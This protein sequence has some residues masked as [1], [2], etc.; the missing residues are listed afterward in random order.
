MDEIKDIKNRDFKKEAELRIPLMVS[1]EGEGKEALNYSFSRF[2][3]DPREIL[4]HVEKL[5]ND[6]LVTTAIVTPEKGEALRSRLSESIRK[7]GKQ[8]STEEFVFESYEIAT[9]LHELDP[10]N[11]PTS[12]AAIKMAEELLS[13]A[14]VALRDERLLNHAEIDAKQALK[15]AMGSQYAFYAEEDNLLT[16]STQIINDRLMEM[17]IDRDDPEDN[18]KTIAMLEALKQSIAQQAIEEYKSKYGH[19]PIYVEAEK[20]ENNIQTYLSYQYYGAY[21]EYERQMLTN[22]RVMNGDSMAVQF[23]FQKYAT[24]IVEKSIRADIVHNSVVNNYTFSNEVLEKLEKV[25]LQQY[26]GHKT[27]GVEQEQ[28]YESLHNLVAAISTYRHGIGNFKKSAEVIEAVF[29]D[30]YIKQYYPGKSRETILG[31]A[32]GAISDIS[33]MESVRKRNALRTEAEMRD[34]MHRYNN[35]TKGDVYTN[36]V[37]KQI[38]GMTK[39]DLYGEKG[40]RRGLDSAMFGLRACLASSLHSKTSVQTGE[41]M[42][43]ECVK[44]YIEETKKEAQEFM[45]MATGQQS[46]LLGPFGISAMLALLAIYKDLKAQAANRQVAKIE[47]EAFKTSN[48]VSELKTENELKAAKFFMPFK[49]SAENYSE[50]KFN[51]REFKTIKGSIFSVF[52]KD[53]S[54]FYGIAS[55]SSPTGNIDA[56]NEYKA[57]LHKE[58]FESIFVKSGLIHRTTEEEMSVSEETIQDLARLRKEESE[59]VAKMQKI[60]TFIT[61]NSLEHANVVISDLENAKRE[62]ESI[63]KDLTSIKVR[64]RDIQ[65]AQERGFKYIHPTGE[66]N[67]TIKSLSVQT[68]RAIEDGLP[69]VEN[70][71]GGKGIVTSLEI[72]EQITYGNAEVQ[73]TILREQEKVLRRAILEEIAHKERKEAESIQN[74]QGL[75]SKILSQQT[76]TPLGSAAPK[77]M[78]Q[79]KINTLV[80]AYMET[81]KLAQDFIASQRAKEGI[82]G[83]LGTL[84]YDGIEPTHL[85]SDIS[86]EEIKTILSFTSREN[87]EDPMQID[88]SYAGDKVTLSGFS[89]QALSTEKEMNEKINKEMGYKWTR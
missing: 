41:S 48:M 58:L 49:N 29:D 81:E 23:Y 83:P 79:R 59:L 14:D 64:I 80:G 24:D 34:L 42:A 68:L 40:R 17:E 86:D 78:A 63:E 85:F 54:T 15:E 89:Q 35:E 56:L 87:H 10:R 60:Q 71:F 6:L 25:K 39:E 82:N 76:K 72:L 11:D 84:M 1:R 9:I 31:Y 77:T 67:Q 21:K 26:N 53:L 69:S 66:N 44:R 88:I 62:F 55:K 2:L 46:I 13:R 50:M 28:K 12:A 36:L 38:V 22:S 8:K 20:I 18:D 61:L 52:A 45:S 65:H 70:N 4:S 16:I 74:S 30:E 5:I 32:K 75:F 37:A 73:L 19:D 57:E 7:I 33:Q 27:C 43:S 51:A 47:Q 3:E